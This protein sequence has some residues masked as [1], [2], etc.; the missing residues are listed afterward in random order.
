MTGSSAHGARVPVRHPRDH[1]ARLAALDAIALADF[2]ARRADL[3]GNA[4]A[5]LRHGL[6]QGGALFLPED[7][8]RAAQARG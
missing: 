5:R 1:A 3:G 8:P 4:K 7:G 6:E 2:E